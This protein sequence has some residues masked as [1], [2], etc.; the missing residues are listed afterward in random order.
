MLIGNDPY[1]GGSHLPDVTVVCPLFDQGAPA[2]Y[3]AVR[4]HHNDIGGAAHGGY[5]AAAQE[6]YF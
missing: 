4:A 5:N 2:F 1:Y 6:I 3:V